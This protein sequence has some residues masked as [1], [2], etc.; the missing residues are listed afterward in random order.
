MFLKLWAK[1]MVKNFRVS[2]I[3]VVNRLIPA[4]YRAGLDER[5]QKEIKR[6]GK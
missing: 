2:N 3:P 6:V 5:A 1:F 4:K